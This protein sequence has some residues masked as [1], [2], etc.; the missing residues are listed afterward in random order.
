MLIN[1]CSLKN[2]L[3]P[4][5]E[6]NQMLIIQRLQFERDRSVFQTLRRTLT[7]VLTAIA[8]VFCFRAI[9]PDA[10]ATNS[11][12]DRPIVAT[13]SVAQAE[14]QKPNSGRLQTIETIRP[15][16]RVVS[17]NPLRHE[18]QTPSDIRPETW[19]LIRL[20]MLQDGT[21][22]DLEFLRPLDWLADANALVGS[23][24]QLTLP[25]IGLD[26]PANVLA[27]D[28]CPEIEPDDGS[29]RMVVTG[30]MKHL[31][32]EVLDVFVS[33]LNEPIGVTAGHSIWSETRQS[34]VL[35]ADL[36]PGEQLRTASEQS[37]AAIEV[38][39][40]RGPPEYV[41]NLEVDGE[42]V[43]H[44]AENA[45]LAHNDSGFAKVV[46]SSGHLAIEVIQ[47][48]VSTATHVRFKEWRI[49]I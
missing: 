17:R 9:T 48:G 36:Q 6:P 8:C 13:T 46:G 21:Q 2:T 16:Q 38:H 25:G 45:V 19:R 24:I 1:K 32:P 40:K 11:D 12:V 39:P 3:L 14:P 34:F 22:F 30:T 15:G 28:P 42:H 49:Q 43:Y 18:T 44:V 33:G 27:I 26:G 4:F 7:V 37:A 23:T 29:G 47:G 41:Y 10:T 31:A 5:W 20:T 35:A